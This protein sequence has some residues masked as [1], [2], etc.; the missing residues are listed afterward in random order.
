M[1]IPG[2]KVKN[3]A[4][5]RPAYNLPELERYQNTKNPPRIYARHDVGISLQ[6]EL[7]RR[8]IVLCETVSRERRRKMDMDAVLITEAVARYKEVYYLM[9]RMAIPAN[10]VFNTPGDYCN[11]FL[12]TEEKIQDVI[13]ANGEH[14]EEHHGYPT[15]DTVALQDYLKELNRRLL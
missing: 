7:E 8:F 12:I 5:F 15:A 10:F 11:F 9:E 6:A 2:A 3:A 1:T 14:L 13:V 4:A